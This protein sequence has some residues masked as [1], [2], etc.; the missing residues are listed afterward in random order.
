MDRVATCWF[1]N[2]SASTPLVGGVIIETH[3]GSDDAGTEYDY[4]EGGGGDDAVWV[5]VGDDADGGA[6]HDTLS[7]SF[8]GSASAVSVSTSVLLSGETDVQTGSAFVNFEAFGQ[9]RGS[10]FSDALFATTQASRAF[11]EAGGG[12]DR[13]SRTPVPSPQPA[14]REPT[15]STAAPRTTSSTA[16]KGSTP[17][18]TRSRRLG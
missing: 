13:Y 18:I 1:R 7:V 11:V 4:I 16:A 12:N 3:R 10:E 6:G 9:L 17:S 14:A 5:G 8:A 15:A 2:T